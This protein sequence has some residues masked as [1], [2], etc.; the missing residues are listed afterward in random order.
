MAR[1]QNTL[2]QYMEWGIKLKNKSS[3]NQLLKKIFSD[4]L[5]KVVVYFVVV[6]LIFAIT[7]WIGSKGDYQWLYDQNEEAYFFW[8]ALF[9]NVYSS[10]YF[11]F[12]L[13]FVIV[14]GF[15]FLLYQLLKKVFSFVTALADSANRLF[16]KNEEEIVLPEELNQLERKLNHLKRE[17][18][19]N[20]R[21]AIEN[22]QK[23]DELIVYMAHDLKTPLTSMIGYLSLLDEI[24]DMPKQKRQKYISIALDKSYK[25]ED[26]I[27]ELFDT[28]R[29]NSEKIIL[30][31]EELNLN[32]MLEQIIDDFYPILKELN[33]KVKFN[34]KESIILFADAN[35]LSR[36]FNNLLKNAIYYSKENSDI[37]IDLTKLDNKVLVK[38]INKGK[39]IPK[40]KLD[41][42]FEKFYRLDTSRN[43]N[44]G[45]SGLGLAIAKDILELHGGNIKAQSSE[46]ETIFIVELPLDR[47]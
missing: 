47:T 4:F 20:E 43:T 30:E 45:G 15:L 39:Q 24:K 18:L 12:V 5:M 38:V 13:I 40:A 19:K 27:N 32:L 26:L 37:E 1:I 11:I 3:D 28:A 29:F 23:K 36:V 34:S 17:A 25:L 35:R 14:G 33:K 42:I 9:Y 2:K 22:E 31:K 10:S 7:I 21:L 16:D 41:K 46:K 44:T 8:K 6:I